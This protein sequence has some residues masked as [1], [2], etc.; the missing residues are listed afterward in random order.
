MRL[1]ARRWL[2]ALRPQRPPIAQ[3]LQ[4]AAHHP[5]LAPA[6]PHRHLLPL[7]PQPCNQ[8]A[9]LTKQVEQTPARPGPPHARAIDIAFERDETA[10]A[11][12]AAPRAD[13]ASR[14]PPTINPTFKACTTDI[15]LHNEC[16]HVGLSID[17]RKHA[18]SRLHC[19]PPKEIERRTVHPPAY[20]V[21]GHSRV[22]P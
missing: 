3:A 18:D 2:V 7:H 13:T 6:F 10:P 9:T 21:A 4:P 14:P 8:L 5:L 20:I 16:A 12:E 19:L 17:A 15:Y 11:A 22:E 1:V